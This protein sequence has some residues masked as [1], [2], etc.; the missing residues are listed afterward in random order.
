M[1]KL[2]VAAVAMIACGVLPAHAQTLSLGFAK[3]AQY[4]YTLHISGEGSLVTS[5]I[6]E[7]YKFDLGAVETVTVGSVGADGIAAVSV[8]LS[9]MS[10]K[11][12]MNGTTNT[13]TPGTGGRPLELK[14]APDGR[15]LSIYGIDVSTMPGYG[16]PGAG[17][18][19][20]VLPDTAAK[21]GDTWSKKYDQSDPNG[22]ASTHVTAESE[23]LRDET[24][25]G[26]KAAVIETKSTATFS[27]VSGTLAA[28]VGSPSQGATTA[29]APGFH[30]TG[31][32]TSD[33]TS[34]IDP[35]AHRVM[36]SVAKGATESSITVGDPSSPLAQG[37]GPLTIKVTSTTNLEPA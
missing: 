7:A 6:T 11:M 33:V 26:V 9:K 20:A 3:G 13:T 22:G 1:R 34:W 19:F 24:F 25:G 5:A 15:V 23:Y 2:A 28:P 10:L 31:T 30:G 32:I 36:R 27:I 16:L 14:I 29:T 35:G 12:T 37:M 18:P 4:K 21:P 17:L 8:A